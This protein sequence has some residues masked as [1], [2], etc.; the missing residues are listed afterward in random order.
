VKDNYQKGPLHRPGTHMDDLLTGVMEIIGYARI[1]KPTFYQLVKHAGF[2]ANQILGTWYAHK[3][4]ISNYFKITT[5][6][7]TSPVIEENDEVEQ[8]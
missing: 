8:N 4:N 2:P 7:C 3:E 6:K 5:S 1:S